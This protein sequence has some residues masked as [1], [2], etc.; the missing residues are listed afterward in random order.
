MEIFGAVRTTDLK[1]LTAMEIGSI[2]GRFT[3]FVATCLRR[4]RKSIRKQRCKL[5]QIKDII[6][7]H[8]KELR[9]TLV[10]FSVSL[11]NNPCY[12]EV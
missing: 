9:N 12:I 6:Q 3:S 10:E 8:K 11:N 1:K 7:T 5:K 2:E 4:D